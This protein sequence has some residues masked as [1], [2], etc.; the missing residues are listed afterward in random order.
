MKPHKE[1]VQELQQDAE[2][3]GGKVNATGSETDSLFGLIGQQ[4][5][6][7]QAL[8]SLL[9][10]AGKKAAELKAINAAARDNCTE[11]SATTAT[12]INEIGTLATR[13]ENTLGGSQHAS[14]ERGQLELEQAKRSTTDAMTGFYTVGSQLDTVQRVT[15]QLLEDITSLQGQVGGLIGD[16]GIV[17]E[18]VGRSGQRMGEAASH[19]HTAASEF[20]T[21]ANSL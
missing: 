17:Q 8:H 14:A 16:V 4:A 2:D 3:V 7:L 11:R 9:V 20:G 13:A 1:R 15:G 10:A 6:G 19:T 5:E 12:F 18:T 21:Y